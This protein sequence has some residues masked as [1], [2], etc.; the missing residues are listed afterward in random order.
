VRIL[1]VNKFLYRRGGSETVFLD[2]MEL[3]AS[4]G[5]QVIPFGTHGAP[6][7]ASRN[8][9]FLPH[10]MDFNR[11]PKGIGAKLRIAGR[12]LYSVE[13]ATKIYRLC[14]DVRPDV[15]HLHNIAHHLS[16]SIIR[17]LARLRI[18]IVI[19]FHDY[20]VVCP[21]YTLRAPDG[22]CRRCAQ[23]R[24]HNAIRFRCMKD[25]YLQ[26]GLVA[27]ET[28]LHRTVLRTYELASAFISPSHFL[29]RTVKEMGFPRP[30]QVIPY[31][32][33]AG[34]RP[35]PRR[36]EAKRLLYFGRLSAEKGLRTLLRAVEGTSLNLRIAGTGPLEKEIKT[37]AQKLENCKV[38]F[39]GHLSPETLRQELATA[40]ASIIPAEWY[41]NQPLSVL[42]SF[43][44][45]CPV[46]AS[47][48]GGLP[49]LVRPGETGFLV[50]PGDVTGLRKALLSASNSLLLASELSKNA[51]EYVTKRHSPQVHLES[52]EELYA[53]LCAKQQP[54]PTEACT[55][56]PS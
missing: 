9:T 29:A 12:V 7:W 32:V 50:P 26:S 1:M 13:A 15:A 33:P 40:M 22:P 23:G 35:L 36:P 2:T 8:A 6:G 41:E 49:E 43:A 24:F 27:A 31:F 38:E 51:K 42:E 37:T 52:L 5:H 47:D 18:P 21:A 14:K 48:I 55:S 56:L 28:F 34:T 44:T 53:G 3:L 19:T 20:K 16:P 4:S 25:S 39:L 45:G 54:Q 10:Q 46:V 30:V 17:T 11:P